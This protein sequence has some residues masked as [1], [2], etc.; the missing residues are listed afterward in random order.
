MQEE[1][2]FQKNQ[3]GKLECKE[4][5]ESMLFFWECWARKLDKL[6]LQ[7]FHMFR[8]KHTSTFISKILDSNEVEASLEKENKI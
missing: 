2:Q 6:M 7:I 5:E 8:L 4:L 3:L 1:I